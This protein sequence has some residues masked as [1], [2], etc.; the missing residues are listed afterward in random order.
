MHELAHIRRGDLWVNLVQTV[1]QIVYFYNP[2]L[3]VAN[4][5]IRRVREQAVDEAVQVAMGEKAGEY[6]ETLVRVAKLAFERPALSL[7]LI[8]V[9]ESKSTLQGRV[10]RMLER[11]LPKSAKLGFLGLIAILVVGAILLPMAK[12][13]SPSIEVPKEIVGIW[14]GQAKVPDTWFNKV[15]LS[16]SL[17]ISEEG[18]ATGNI[19]DAEFYDGVLKTDKIARIGK[20][21]ICS[22]RQTKRW[23]KR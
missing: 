10:K 4:A 2:L 6:P 7:R 14:E 11:P 13:G 16:V 15:N 20:Q 17:T 21:R 18:I 19:G 9:V 5:V 3:W 12:A 22:R 1:L 8:G 23:Y